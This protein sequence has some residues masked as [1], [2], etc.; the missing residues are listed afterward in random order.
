MHGKA[1]VT[2]ANGFIGSHLVEGLLARGY[3][4]RGLVRKTSN[5]EWLSGL[6][7]ELNYGEVTNKP[8]LYPAV[9]D[10][11]F[12]FHIAGTT[13]ARNKSEYEFINYQGT[14]NLLEVCVESNPQ[15]KRFVYFSSLAA[16][17]PSNNSH[18]KNEAAECSP[19]SDYGEVKLKAEKLAVEFGKSLPTVILRLPA[20]YGPRDREGITY[21][22]ILKKG[23]RPVFGETYSALFIN[24][25]VTAAILCAENNIPSGAIYFVSDGDCHSLDEMAEI[26]EKLMGVSTL[27]FKVPK[28]ILNFYAC[29]Q[30]KFSKN[31]SII[32]QDKIKELSQKCWTCDTTKIRNNLG[33]SPKF[34]LEEG[35]KLTIGWYK[36]RR[37]L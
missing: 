31:Q 34:S 5:L 15:I 35:L 6:P 18:P 27:R 19:V 13:K 37:W 21:F 9:K 23:I 25:A 10:V 36:E 24:D 3:Q 22:K 16:A 26:A 12:I 28:P 17:G 20:V 33:F 14:K 30:D 32:N 1:L 4:V 8:S 11:D 2:G 29:L 7:I